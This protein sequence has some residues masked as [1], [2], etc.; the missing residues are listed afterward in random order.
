MVSELKRL[1]KTP[2]DVDLVV[3]CQLVETMFPQATIPTSALIISLLSL[4]SMGNSDRFSIGFVAMRCL[5]VNKPWDCNPTNA[6]EELL[7]KRMSKERFP[8]FGFYDELWMTELD[9]QA[10]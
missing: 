5:L 10:H 4:I 6:R 3:G 9:Y 7:G 8:N 2:D 1:Y